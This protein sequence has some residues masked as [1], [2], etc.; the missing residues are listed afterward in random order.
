MT[1]G[2][3]NIDL[4][5]KKDQ[6]YGMIFDELSFA[7]LRVAL[8]R[9]RA[10]SWG[11]GRL[12]AHPRP[13]M[14]VSDHRP[15]A[16]NDKKYDLH[17]NKNCQNHDIPMLFDHRIL[18]AY[19]KTSRGNVWHSKTWISLHM[20]HP[21]GNKAAVNE[22]ARLSPIHWQMLHCHGDYQLANCREGI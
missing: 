16:L 8:W 15:G 9:M 12:D 11:G 2:G 19:P 4:R 10:V 7:F 6:Y 14:D 17:T 20:I 22:W 3:L 1:T 21:H 5:K 13:N 18:F